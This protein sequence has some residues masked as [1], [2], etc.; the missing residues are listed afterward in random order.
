MVTETKS[1]G[2]ITL[3]YLGKTSGAI[4]LAYLGGG[5]TT[6]DGFTCL[7]GV[8]GSSGGNINNISFSS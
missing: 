1:S 8:G 5:L 3:A 4:I 6:A 2:V 7:D